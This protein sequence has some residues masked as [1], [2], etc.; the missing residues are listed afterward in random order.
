MNILSIDLGH[1]SVKFLELTH[2]RKNISLNYFH[3]IPLSHARK[4]L[5]DDKSIQELQ[6]EIIK[7]FMEQRPSTAR[8]IYQIPDKIITTRY[9]QLPVTK[10]KK[11][12]MMIPFQ[13]DENLPFQISQAHHTG[14]IYKTP[15]G[16]ASIIGI[17]KL[18]D[19][20]PFY[21]ELSSRNI[22]PN[23]LTNELFSLHSYLKL[24]D[25]LGIR[26][27]FMTGP[28]CVLDIGHDS[29]KAYFFHKGNVVSNHVC[30]VAGSKINDIIAKTYGISEEEA[31]KYKHKNC[32]FLTSKQYDDVNED[33]QEFAKLMKQGMLPLLQDLKRWLLGF[34]IK[35]GESLNTIYL[36]GGTSNIK[37]IDN[38][39]A[40]AVG[41]NVTKL[42]LFDFNRKQKIEIT[43][44]KKA[45]GNI[46]ILMGF[47]LASKIP[48][49][50]FLKGAYSPSSST[51]LPLH[52]AV[53]LGVRIAAVCLLLILA[54]AVEKTILSRD[55]KQLSNHLRVMLKKP[56]IGIS[57][58]NR[59]LLKRSPEK[60]LT[61]MK[62][63]NNKIKRE[64]ETVME[65]LSLNA[66]EPLSNLSK[67]I[68]RDINVE[69]VSYESSKESLSATFK[70]EKNEELIKLKSLLESSK[71]NN[72][73]IILDKK[74]KNLSMS[75]VE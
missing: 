54:M 35:Q 19:F 36:T 70:S 38:F 31:V 2:E 40:E 41:C 11:A 1:Y 28:F 71:F 10:R 24:A 67:I 63:K 69:M 49:A 50:N 46:C 20:D 72:A 33:Q 59:N 65:A 14:I 75:Q 55:D 60:L 66:M 5:S 26:K 73:K 42:N 32:F 74:R 44:E 23:V 4:H 51:T 12:E 37:N 8:V 27:S 18:D 48:P 6:L 47:S 68:T 61:L 39:I 43:P 16:M 3:E 21:A 22:L 56:A 62:N 15:K 57:V 13:L 58:K 30:N 9:I 17:S 52:S 29:T 7:N 34:R 64:I 25:N 53:F 45:S